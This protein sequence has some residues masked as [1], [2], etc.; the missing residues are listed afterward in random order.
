MKL[1]SLITTNSALVDLIEQNGGAV[2]MSW[3]NGLI[4]NG[5]WLVRVKPERLLR[6]EFAVGTNTDVPPSPYGTFQMDG[7][8]E[9]RLETWRRNDPIIFRRRGLC[10]TAYRVHP[11][12]VHVDSRYLDTILAIFGMTTYDD[13]YRLL[14]KAE[15]DAVLVVIDGEF[16]AAIMPLEP[17]QWRYAE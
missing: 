11:G 5:H 8:T 15:D 16:R 14:V 13:G 7:Y 12:S 4:S 9:G 1:S 6:H 10:E 2:L 3:G 17:L